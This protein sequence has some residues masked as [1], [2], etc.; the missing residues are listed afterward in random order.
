VTRSILTAL[1]VLF[2]LPAYATQCLPTQQ[3]WELHKAKRGE[4]RQSVGLDGNGHILTVWANE[5]TGTWALTVTR[6]DG[7]TCL[8]TLGTHHTPLDEAAGE[9]M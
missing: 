9:V 6:P 7:L 4:S 8:V 3:A 1:A 5:R 2:A